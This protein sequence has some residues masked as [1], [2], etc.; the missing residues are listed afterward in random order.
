MLAY[1]V[2]KRSQRKESAEVVSELNNESSELS[3]ERQDDSVFDMS[4][5][6]QVHTYLQYHPCDS[7]IA[8]LKALFETTSGADGDRS[9]SRVFDENLLVL[10][11]RKKPHSLVA[12]EMLFHGHPLNEPYLTSS[13]RQLQLSNYAKLKRCNM[14]LRNAIY[15]VGAPD[16]Y[17]VL[18]PGEVFVGYPCDGLGGVKRDRAWNDQGD[19]VVTRNPC[20]HPGDVRKLKAVDSLLLSEYL[21]GTSGGVIFFSTQ[22]LRSD[23]DCMGGGDFDGDLYLVLLSS[24]AMVPYVNQVDPFQSAAGENASSNE[25]HV[26]ET[27]SWDIFKYLGDFGRKSLVGCYTNAW[28]ALA[29]HFG[30]DDSRAIECCRIVYDALDAAKTGKKVKTNESFL[31]EPKPHYLEKRDAR[32]STSLLGKLYDM[33]IAAEKDVRID[34]AVDSFF[35]ENGKLPLDPDL[36][37]AQYD[38]RIY[39][40]WM[41][42]LQAYKDQVIRSF[43]DRMSPDD[44]LSAQFDSYRKIFISESLE[45]MKRHPSFQRQGPDAVEFNSLILSKCMKNLASHIYQITYL[46]AKRRNSASSPDNSLFR[47]SVSFC[48]EI[49][50]RFLHRIKFDA[51]R[52]KFKQNALD[53]ILSSELPFVSTF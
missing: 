27:V 14:R 32:Y 17:G 24:C 28:L 42:H 26:T 50:G 16:P 11:A 33:V 15:L 5:L 7:H 52:K 25:L 1:R 48:W 47:Y 41:E 20:L 36:A 39:V 30:A 12:F 37:F 8:T 18:E 9:S 6:S 35:L 43:E 38:E 21:V 13:L 45:M 49:C 23:A 10:D 3:R 29:D 4:Q 53:T 19:V 22:G 44:I 40:K 46:T 51:L 31:E 2:V 34:P